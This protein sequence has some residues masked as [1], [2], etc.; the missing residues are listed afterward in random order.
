VVV[1]FFQQMIDYLMNF[2]TQED[3]MARYLT[4]NY[5]SEDL[6]LDMLYVINLK[7]KDN[8]INPLE[9]QY[10][11]I[12]QN[13]KLMRNQ[14]RDHA[15]LVGFLINWICYGSNLSRLWLKRQ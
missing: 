1:E 7:N 2:P 15:G 9:M 8:E 13:S 4:L 5:L 12:E 14:G 11:Q 10:N 6:D 3:R